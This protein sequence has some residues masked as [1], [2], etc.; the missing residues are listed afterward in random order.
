MPPDYVCPEDQSYCTLFIV[1]TKP[2]STGSV[3]LASA[4]PNAAP[5]IDPRYLSSP[6]DIVVLRN[7]IR[8]GLSLWKTKTLQ[9]FYIN[10]ILVPSSDSSEDIDVSEIQVL[11]LWS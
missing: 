10:D 11:A 4:D 7:A 3:K 5:L 2:Q 8:E 6:Y 9:P 1:P